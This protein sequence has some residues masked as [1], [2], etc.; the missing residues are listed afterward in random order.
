MDKILLIIGVLQFSP[1]LKA[2]VL[3][4]KQ[5]IVMPTMMLCSQLSAHLSRKQDSSEIGFCT[6]VARPYTP[7]TPAPEVPD[8]GSAESHTQK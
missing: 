2:E 1:E 4:I 8:Y 5:E 3:V 6:F 7:P